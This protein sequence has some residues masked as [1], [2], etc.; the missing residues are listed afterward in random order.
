L[1]QK[2]V[3]LSEHQSKTL[4]KNKLKSKKLL[5]GFGILFTPQTKCLGYLF[6]NAKIKNKYDTFF[7]FW[8]YFSEKL[9]NSF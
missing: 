7:V 9:K 4:S 8:H 2:L 3:A 6:W 5:L 1:R